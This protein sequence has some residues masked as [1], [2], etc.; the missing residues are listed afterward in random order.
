MK[1]ACPKGTPGAH[2]AWPSD[3]SWENA[4]R[5]LA[6][7]RA[8]RLSEADTAE[9]VEA[10]IGRAAAATWF[11]YI[12]KQDLPNAA[13][14]LDGKERF[15]HDPRRVDRTATVLNACVALVTPK[16]AAKRVPRTEAFWRLIGGLLTDQMSQDILVA[17]AQAM[18]AASLH[19]GKVAVP[20]LSKL[21]PLI[22]AA[23]I[24]PGA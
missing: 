11:E 24:K 21:H 6:S 8:H 16:D 12:D 22:K 1:N 10:F 23:G 4:A 18:V 14:V 19:T 2:R 20:N 15:D 13:D 3:R 9:F 7:A 17:P 5:A